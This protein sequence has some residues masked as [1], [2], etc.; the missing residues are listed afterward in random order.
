[1]DQNCFLV[2]NFLVSV[3]FSPFS[4]NY[5]SMFGLFRSISVHFGPFRSILVHSVRFRPHFQPI[6]CRILI[7]FWFIFSSFVVHLVR[8]SVFGPLFRKKLFFDQEPENSVI[9]YRKYSLRKRHFGL[10]LMFR[11]GYWSLHFVFL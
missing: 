11:W 6:F 7:H 5:W 4:I 1:M 9:F 2:I 8:V 3:N 10:C